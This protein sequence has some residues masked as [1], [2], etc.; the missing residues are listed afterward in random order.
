MQSVFTMNIV[1]GY[2]YSYPVTCDQ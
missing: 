1:I 2:E